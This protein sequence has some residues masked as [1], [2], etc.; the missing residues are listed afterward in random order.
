V[1]PL[2]YYL[3]PHFFLKFVEGKLVLWDYKNHNQFLIKDAYLQRLTEISHEKEGSSSPLDK[4]LLSLNII[5]ESP[6]EPSA[7][8]WDVLSQIY[9]LGVQ[10]LAMPSTESTEEWI[11]DYIH[12]C[13]GLD[14]T[15]E[16]FFVELEGEKI[17]LPKPEPEKYLSTPLWETFKK[18]KTSRNFDGMSISL[19]LLSTLLYAAFGLIHGDWNEEENA[20]FLRLGFRKSYPSAGAVHPVEA[21]V[22]A[23]NVEGLEQGIYHYSSHTHQLIKRGNPL[24]SQELIKLLGGQFFAK[25]IAAGIFLVGHFEKA[26]SKYKHSRSYRDI[27]LEAGHGS[28]NFLLAA[29]AANLKTWVTA[30][31]FDSAVSDKLHLTAEIEAPLI[32]LGIGHGDA[33]SI[34]QKI[35]NHLTKNK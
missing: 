5:T 18:R 25:G 13:K 7:W 6:P 8:K 28:Q 10:D 35:I 22:I 20:P 12:F 29:T 14:V 17:T 1:K 30:Y 16:T 23:M 9:H 4:E 31:F 2:K 34:P 11:A 27:F 24:S 19:P 21:Y 15:P 33:S 3:S 26:W 32:F